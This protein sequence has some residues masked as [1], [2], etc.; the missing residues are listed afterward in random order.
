MRLPPGTLERC[1]GEINRLGE[2]CPA[3]HG[4]DA[5][6]ER[7]LGRLKLAGGAPGRSGTA[8]VTFD[9]FRPALGGAADATDGVPV[10]D[11]GEI[12]GAKG[13]S[14]GSIFI[15]RLA[16]VQPLYPVTPRGECLLVP[17][18]HSLGVF[19]DALLPDEVRHGLQFGQV[20]FPLLQRIERAGSLGQ[21][22]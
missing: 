1:F 11:H 12:I 15:N 3:D 16:S 17:H 19:D 2:R 8:T 22:Y 7:G 13:Q 21:P 5:S 4:L 14:S 20:L 18:D 9:D 10:I 6:P